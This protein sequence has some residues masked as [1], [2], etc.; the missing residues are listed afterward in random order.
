E[1]PIVQ[2]DTPIGPDECEQI[3][4][5]LAA[6]PEVKAFHAGTS[7]LG[8]PIWSLEVGLPSRGKYIS[9]ARAITAKPVLFVTG[10]QH[11]N[12]VSSTSHILR[13]AE[14]LATDPEIRRLL[15]RVP[16]ILHPMT[17]PD[18]AALVEELSWDTPDFMLH[19][20]YLGALGS[21]VTSE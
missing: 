6:F 20:G 2:W 8:H 9:Q 18:G 12:E 7:Y 10:R 5:R 15:D 3:I 21:D 1:T 13:L 4:R 19:A 11:A 16:F 17:N 14:L